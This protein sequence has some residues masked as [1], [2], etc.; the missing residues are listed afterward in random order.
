MATQ[1]D[2]AVKKDLTAEVA[3]WIEAFDEVVA[4]DWEQGAALLAALR[5]RAR[6]A[7]LHAAL[8]EKLFAQR[9]TVVKAA[10][11]VAALAG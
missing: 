6:E 5:S 3:E 4:N 9:A 7:E 2:D 10:E 8:M 11:V 1:T